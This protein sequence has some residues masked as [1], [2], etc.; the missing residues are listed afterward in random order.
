VSD[1]AAAASLDRL[2]VTTSR[3]RGRVD[4]RVAT[5][6]RRHANAQDTLMIATAVAIQARDEELSARA[7]AASSQ[8]SVHPDDRGRRGLSNFAYGFLLV[9]VWAVNLPVAVATFQVFGESLAFTVLLALFADTVFLAIAHGV[10]VTLRRAHLAHDP[11]LVLGVE[12]V[13]GWAL[14]LLGIVGALASGLVRWSYLEATGTGAGPGGVLFTTILALATFVLAALAAWRHH[15]PAVADAERAGRLRRRADRRVT[16]ARHRVR[17][18]AEGWD[19][20]VTRRRLLAQRIVG[21]ADRRIRHARALAHRDLRLATVE[22]PAW[23]AHERSLA[24][25]PVLGSPLQPLQLDPGAAV[26][27]TVPPVDGDPRRPTAA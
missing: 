17:A 1:H 13:L 25:M 2:G 10:G 11:G 14:F 15:Q 21:R 18:T 27:P 26:P 8:A 9:I 23:L 4:R 22:E 12:L 3:R 20:R 16:A 7:A 5:A 6:F 24:C 19:H